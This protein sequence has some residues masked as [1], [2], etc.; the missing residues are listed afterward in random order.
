MVLVEVGGGEG[1]GIA[2]HHDGCVVVWVGLD[3]YVVDWWW[4]GIAV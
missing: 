1:M 3:W 2:Y 4:F